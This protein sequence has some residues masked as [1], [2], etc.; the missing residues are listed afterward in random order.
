M[1]V[2]ATI[3]GRRRLLRTLDVGLRGAFLE[4]EET[5]ELWDP[6]EIEVTPSGRDP[7]IRNGVVVR[8]VPADEAAEK[9]Q[10]VGVGIEFFDDDP[11]WERIVAEGM[12]DMT[13]PPQPL[14]PFTGPP[15]P[16]SRPGS[17][18]C[19]GPLVRT[20][21][22][23]ARADS[24]RLYRIA[25]ASPQRWKELMKQFL[26]GGGVRLQQ[27]QA[28]ALPTPAVVVAID[29]ETNHEW[30]LPGTAVPT[31]TNSSRQ[32]GVLLRFLP[33]G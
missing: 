24:P 19:P 5:P 2:V 18:L 3:G 10:A 13:P 27:V 12:E 4:Y 17:S 25:P 32:S 33:N 20:G 11:A 22:P 9:A 29:P 6:V 14:V 26:D 21:A 31:N 28:V 7:L 23:M 1:L 8:H 15:G 16:L 30:F